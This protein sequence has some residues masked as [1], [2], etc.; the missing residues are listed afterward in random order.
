MVT[1]SCPLDIYM[2]LET[3]VGKVVTMPVGLFATDGRVQPYFPKNG[4]GL[5]GAEEG[6]APA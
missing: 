3:K 5:T 1:L 2:R 4:Q 6:H